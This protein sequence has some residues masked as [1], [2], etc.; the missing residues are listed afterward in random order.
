M[1]TFIPALRQLAIASLDYYLGGSSIPK[2]PKR[3]KPFF[4]TS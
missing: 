4:S 2:T 1:M 3:V